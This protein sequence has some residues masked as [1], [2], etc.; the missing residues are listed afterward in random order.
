M[1]VLF[2]I[3]FGLFGDPAWIAIIRFTGNRVLD[4]A[5]KAERRFGVEHVNPGRGRIRND[6]HVAGLNCSPTTD[7]GAVK[8]QAI[9]KDILAVFVQR[10]GEVLPSTEKIGELEIDQFNSLIFDK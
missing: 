6:E 7:A 10:R 4:G 5:D 9:R 1:P 2:E 3:S 8:A